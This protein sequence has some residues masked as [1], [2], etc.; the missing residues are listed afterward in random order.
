MIIYITVDGGGYLSIPIELEIR[1]LLNEQG[2]P[3]LVADHLVRWLETRRLSAD[4]CEPIYKFFFNCGFYATLV[5]Q[6]VKSIAT[7][8]PISWQYFSEALK[9][10][11]DV[12]NEKIVDAII[13]GATSQNLLEQ[14]AQSSAL[15]QFEESLKKIRKQRTEL[16]QFQYTDRRQ[17]II[18]QIQI[19][20][21]QRLFLEENHLIDQLCRLFPSDPDN[22]KFRSNY[23]ER[24]A[25]EI[26]NEKIRKRRSYHRDKISIQEPTDISQCRHNIAQQI[27]SLSEEYPE[28][29]YDLSMTMN[30]LDD[31]EAALKALE[32]SP[33]HPAKDWLQLELLIAS[34]RYVDALEE[35]RLLEL[36]YASDP[37]ATFATTYCRALALWGLKQRNEAI[38]LMQ[39][40]INIRPHYRAAHS[41]YLQWIGEMP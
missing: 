10:C 37:E 41:L 9:F 23:N 2:H 19:V 13:E 28:Q 39:E 15:D 11:P 27:Q 33:D 4:E 20:R 8:R 30:F 16:L 32:N 17:Q 35:A 5:T 3:D 6:G 21:T 22:E 38:S 25:G 24:W 29:A 26:I 31:P 1:T 14:L 34:E 18:E 12:L 36:K 7:M 40:I